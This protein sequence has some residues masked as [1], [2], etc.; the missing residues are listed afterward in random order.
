MLIVALV[1]AVIGLASLVTA[2][3]T[4]NEL[5]AWV[6]IGASVL[7]V[8]LLIV[9]AIRERQTRSVVADQDLATADDAVAAAPATVDNTYENFDAEYPDEA[10]APA[11]ETADAVVDE[12]DEEPSA[13]DVVVSLGPLEPLP[14]AVIVPTSV[15]SSL[16]ASGQTSMCSLTMKPSTFI[17]L[18]SMSAGLAI[19]SGAPS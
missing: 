12:E 16:S 1:L 3:V 5:I 6:C 4:G 10:A 7:G 18:M 14:Q 19:G 13:A 15:P 9:D 2:V 11:A 8:I 17:R